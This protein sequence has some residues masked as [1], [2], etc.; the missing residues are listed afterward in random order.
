M[1]QKAFSEVIRL[2][3][4]R[5]SIKAHSVIER[6]STI[7]RYYFLIVTLNLNSE[8]ITELFLPDQKFI[9]ISQNISRNIMQNLIRTAWKSGIFHNYFVTFL[10]H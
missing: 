6:K 7:N 9:A 1:L 10:L 3:S 2:L 5:R 4:C 8:I